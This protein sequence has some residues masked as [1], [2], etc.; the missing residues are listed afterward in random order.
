MIVNVRTSSTTIIYMSSNLNVYTSFGGVYIKGL[1]GEL[2][3]PFGVFV[4]RNCLIISFLLS[5]GIKSNILNMIKGLRMNHV[6]WL[7]LRGSGFKANIDKQTLILKLGFSHCVS[8]NIPLAVS[9]DIYQNVKI[10]ITGP[11]LQKVTFMAQVVKS[12]RMP[13]AYKAKGVLYRFDETKTKSGKR[14]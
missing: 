2:V 8:I 14:R 7:V 1:T 10:R 6:K 13:D 11:C 12:R 9:I 5:G 3:L 4:K